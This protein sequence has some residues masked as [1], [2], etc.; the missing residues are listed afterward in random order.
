M[1]LISFLSLPVLYLFACFFF[2]GSDSQSTHCFDESSILVKGIDLGGT[3]GFW[4]WRPAAEKLSQDC[5]DEGGWTFV[6]NLDLDSC[7]GSF[8]VKGSFVTSFPSFDLTYCDRF[9]GLTWPEV[10]GLSVLVSCTWADKNWMSVP[11]KICYHRTGAKIV[12]H[13]NRSVAIN[14]Y[15]IY[16]RN[17]Q[18]THNL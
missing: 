2:S 10:R 7:L 14:W 4:F 13:G 5:W 11:T 1:T 16:L 17:L 8:T 9:P 12:F 3:R 6:F 18:S 15:S